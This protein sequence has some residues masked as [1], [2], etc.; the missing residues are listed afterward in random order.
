MG[1]RINADIETSSGPSN[2]VYIRVDGFRWNKLGNEMTFT[3]TT[4]N[5]KEEADNFATT[6]LGDDPGNAVGL[7]SPVM[8]Y[9][10]N[11]DSEGVDI[12]LPNFFKF[13]PQY[14]GTVELPIFEE[15]EI[16]EEIPY[17]SFD[18][19]G[20]EITLYRTKV[21]TE[22]VQVGTETVEKIFLDKKA[23]SNPIEYCYKELKD[24]ISAMVPIH[25]LEII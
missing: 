25:Q 1:L 5:S 23:I 15:K 10:K 3:T 7:L 8:T 13:I 2:A 21:K 24:R 17:V 6:Y 11:N 9:Y 19:E 20:E 22:K 18:S 14:K 16:S 4:W 12:T